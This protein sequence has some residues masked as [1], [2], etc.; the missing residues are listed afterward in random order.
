MKHLLIIFLIII[1]TSVIFT[2]ETKE[3]FNKEACNVSI[4][5]IQ[6]LH[7]MIPHHQVAIDMSILLQKKTKNPTMHNIINV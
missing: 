2:K 6:Y 1:I 3:H 5:D 7:H 4:T